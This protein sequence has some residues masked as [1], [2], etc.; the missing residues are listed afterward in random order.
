[1][2]PTTISPTA[3]GSE[4]ERVRE[5]AIRLG[6]PGYR[7]VSDVELVRDY[8]FATVPADGH[9]P[10]T[11]EWLREC[12]GFYSPIDG[13]W[14]HGNLTGT[15]CFEDDGLSWWHVGNRTANITTRHQ[16][17]QIMAALGIEPKPPAPA[18]QPEKRPGK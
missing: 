8:V 1:M 13:A 7:E 11:A 9:L 2:T 15:F 14:R 10:I 16:F 6:A 18:Y 12:W 17:A 4:L 5:A 3:P